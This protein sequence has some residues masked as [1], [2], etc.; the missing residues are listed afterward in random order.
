MS[1]QK[2]DAVQCKK[3]EHTVKASDPEAD[4]ANTNDN[5]NQERYKDNPNKRGRNKRKR[6]E[7]MRRDVALSPWL[8][9]CSCFR[10]TIKESAPDND[11]F[12]K[13]SLPDRTILMAAA[14][15]KWKEVVYKDI[16]GGK[17]DKPNSKELMDHLY[18]Y[19]WTYKGNGEMEFKRVYNLEK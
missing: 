13:K 12:K 8:N 14:Y 7:K 11:E 16:N 15:K 9:F 19:T 10:H 2:N 5:R 3:E 18:D 4:P 17:G 1:E 6:N